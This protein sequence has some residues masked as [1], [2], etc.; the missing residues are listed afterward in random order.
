MNDLPRWLVIVMGQDEQLAH[1]AL[2]IEPATS[3]MYTQL[4]RRMRA[5]G[6]NRI[7]HHAYQTLT[8]PY[9][10][11][12]AVDVVNGALVRITT[13]MASV[14]AGTAAAPPFPLTSRW[15]ASARARR[16]LVGLVP[17]GSLADGDDTV[18]QA[19]LV[20]AVEDGL[21]LGASARARFDLPVSRP[22]A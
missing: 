16:T 17:P 11:H 19:A 5:G 21:L 1:S 8:W 6:F 10:A 12:A 18:K 14:Y 13:G 15:I 20:D 22:K 4:R 3:E 9:A 2:V 7:T